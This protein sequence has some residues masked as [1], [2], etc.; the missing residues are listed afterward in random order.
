MEIEI[1]IG[2]NTETVRFTD[3]DTSTREFNEDYNNKHYN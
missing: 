2:G 3:N 1:T